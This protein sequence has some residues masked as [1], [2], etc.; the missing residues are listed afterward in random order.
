VQTTPVRVFVVASVRLYEEGLADVLA[1]DPRFLVSG[2]ARTVPEG[3]ERMRALAEPPHV[4][5]LDLGRPDGLAAA[6]A[7]REELPGVRQIALG[8]AEVEP[9]VIAWAEA[10]VDGFVSREASLDDLMATA[11]TVA[12]GET[13]CSPRVAAALLRRVASM[14]RD[15]APVIAHA[16]LTA[17]EHEIVGLIDEGLSN[18]EIAMRLRIELPTVKNH[19]HNLLE[20]LHVRRR[21]EAAAMVRGEQHALRS[22]ARN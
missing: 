1:R 15:G 12:E 8:I 7:L 5:L 17:R 20:K 11:V 21:G 19:V 22:L 9:D 10:G 13:L 14:A 3:L 2:T 16:P 6:R 4:A 18:K